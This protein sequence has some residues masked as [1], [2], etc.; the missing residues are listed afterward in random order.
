MGT[1][2]F[3]VPSLKALL[4]NGY[5]VSAVITAP[6][7]PS[8][9]GQK[10][11][12]S[13]VKEFVLAFNET[14]LKD[15]SNIKPDFKPLPILQPEKLKNPDFLEHLQ[16]YKAD[17]HIVVAFRMLPQLIWAMPPLG[18][19]NL[20]ASLLP[21]YRGAA[22]INWAII[23]GEKESGITTFFL[24][25]EIDAG[26]I[27]LQETIS[28]ES[29]ETAGEYHDRLMI[30]GARLVIKT[31]QE[32][33]NHCKDEP[34]KVLPLPPLDEG[35]N[36]NNLPT[37]SYPLAPKLDKT[38][39]LIYWER[40]T[41]SIFNLIRGLSPFPTAYTYLNNQILKIYKAKMVCQVHKHLA[42]H[43][44]TDG[45]TFLRFYANDGYLDIVDLQLENKKRMKTEEL[46][47]GIRKDFF[48]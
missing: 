2:P 47:R 15:V 30:E 4:E 10:V 29:D 39:G 9:R 31:V 19:F 11:H 1:P 25:E 21:K 48:V 46:L 20:H 28:I 13:A 44:E 43:L 42:G 7:R 37:S 23:N 17:L 24:N 32:I 45:K 27:I 33:E 8:G 12:Y 40:S 34:N 35:D 26:K 38:T 6:D 36:E 3:A 14:W 22:P 41:E 16:S 18:T 5:E